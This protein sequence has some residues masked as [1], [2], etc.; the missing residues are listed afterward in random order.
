MKKNILILVIALFSSSI[1]AQ[2]D[3]ITK[4]SGETVSGKV[5]R[6]DEYIVVYKYDGEDAENSI[7]KY[8]IEKIVYGKSGRV[9]QV[10]EKIV[11]NGEDDWEKVIILEDK[12]YIAGLK[13]VVEV[14][15]KT[16]FINMHT[17]NTGDS[18]ADK[19]LKMEAAKLGCPFVFMTADKDINESGANGVSFGAVQSIRKGIAYKY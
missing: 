13:K 4:H 9:E 8:A 10:T 16:A 11:V 5:V 18:K 12:S 6:V 15:G 17:G 7:S 14:K 19:K 1:F 2:V 3:V